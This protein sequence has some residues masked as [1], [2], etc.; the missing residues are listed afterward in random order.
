VD[1]ADSFV[2]V[3]LHL[4]KTGGTTING[5]LHDHMEWD[6]EVV[7]LGLWGN[8]YR[9]QEG[10]VPFEERSADDRSRVR[11]I[12]GH[13]AYFGIHQLVEGKR[14]RYLTFLRDPAD[15]I[16]S[17]YNFRSARGDVGDFWT[18]YEGY[19][20]N[21][22]LKW[23]RKRLNGPRTIGEVMEALRGFWFVGVTERLDDDLPRLF[24]VL[25][26]PHDFRDRRVAG[27]ERDLE[28]L[29]HPDEGRLVKRKVVVDDD[30]R[31]RLHE[32]NPR[33]LRLY[34]F[35]LRRRERSLGALPQ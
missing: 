26:L 5:H 24:R 29:D 19:R 11:V 28:G 17:T 20:R 31:A 8:R 35:A 2:Y 3:F 16:V 25:D 12:T 14:P 15:R 32:D 21:T 9:E 22:G 13:G 23:L 34:R 30:M 33:D 6:E 27:A 7:H 10:R 1:S 4:P 18:W